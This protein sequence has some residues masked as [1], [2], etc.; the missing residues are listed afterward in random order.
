[1]KAVRYGYFSSGQTAVSAVITARK[2]VPKS[3]STGG[4]QKTLGQDDFLKLLAQQFQ[5]QD[6][7]KPMDDTSFIAQMAQFSSL[8]QAKAMQADMAALRSQQD[9]T[10]ASGLLGREVNLQLD[11]NK[12]VSGVVSSVDMQAGSP[13]IVVNGTAYDMSKLVAVSEPGARKAVMASSGTMARS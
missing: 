1:M 6:P 13:K 7:M 9:F 11:Q 12:K 10:Q 4:Q 5:S 3:T 2:Y 8:E